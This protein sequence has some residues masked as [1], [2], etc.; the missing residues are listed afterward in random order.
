MMN[1]QRFLFNLYYYYGLGIEHGLLQ[2]DACLWGGVEALAQRGVEEA[3]L[4]EIILVL[5]NGEVTELMI[6]N[7][8]SCWLIAFRKAKIAGCY[9]GFR[10]V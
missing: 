7:G 3:A 2:A 10:G 5:N 1:T 6:Y 9:P 8:L 4:D